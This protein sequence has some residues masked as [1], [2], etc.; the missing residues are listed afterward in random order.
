[1]VPLFGHH[2]PEEIKQ[3]DNPPIFKV[4]GL[5]GDRMVRANL[6]AVVAQ[7]AA[8]RAEG[9]LRFVGTPFGVVTPAATKRTPLQEHRRADTGAVVDRI[10]ADV[11]NCT[12]V[13]PVHCT[14]KA[15]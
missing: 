13:H 4:R 1:M 7:D 14:N 15:N 12:G 10:F 11:E 9:Q 8:G 5:A 2:K 6:Q 3:R